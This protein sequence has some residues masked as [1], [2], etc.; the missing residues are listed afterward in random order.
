MENHN[1]L[2]GMLHLI[3]AKSKKKDVQSDPNMM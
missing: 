3:F 1:L 2:N